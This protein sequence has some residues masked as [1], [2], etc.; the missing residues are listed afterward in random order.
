[1]P[2]PLPRWITRV[3]AKRSL[4]ETI[5]NAT[6]LVVARFGGA[7][8]NFVFTLLLAQQ[9]APSQ[10]GFVM[11]AMSLAILVSLF[12]TLNMENGAVR[13]LL[14]P[15]EKGN[16]AEASGFVHFGRKVLFWTSPF[17]I[18]FFLVFMLASQSLKNELTRSEIWGVVFAAAAIPVLSMLR[19]GSSWGHALSKIIK[20]M[21]SW[22]FFRPAFLCLLTGSLVVFGITLSVDRILLASFLACGGAFVIQFFL[23]RNAFVFAREV[24]PDTTRSKEWMRTGLYLSVT[25]LLIDYF[26]NVVVVTSALGLTDDDVA[27]LAIALRFTGFLRMG[28]MAVNMAVSPR[29]SKA[30]SA[31]QHADAHGLLSQSTHLKFWPTIVV[32]A[33]VWW[34]APWLISLFGAEYATAVWPLRLFALLPLFAAFFGPS[35]MILNITGRQQQIFRVSAVS[36]ALLI[37]AVPVAGIAFGL[38]GATAAAVVTV[39]FWEWALYDRT[40]RETGIDASILGATHMRAQ[41]IRPGGGVSL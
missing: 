40:R 1:M 39:F 21:L 29:I 28:L 7:V 34:L 9:L 24:K 26:Q 19:L 31:E 17:V 22:A 16:R 38:H 30:I 35:I 33:L 3:L 23:L 4:M 18:V 12:T 8:A 37:I 36:L 32:T 10:V 20:S 25:I 27:R 5:G 11:T 15:L 41:G 2:A 13:H 6:A 14:Q